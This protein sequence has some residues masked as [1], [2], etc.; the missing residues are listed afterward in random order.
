MKH[1]AN[2]ELPQWVESDR[3]L[4]TDFNEAMAKID[5]GLK[6]ALET[7][8]GRVTPEALAAASSNL[9]AQI[10]ACGNCRI[11][12][13]SY[14]GNGKYGKDNAVEIRFS[15]KP[16]LVLIG[17]YEHTSSGMFPS[18]LMRGINRSSS[19]SS[20]SPMQLEWAEKSVKMWVTDKD[21]S[22]WMNNDSGCQYYYVA[23]GT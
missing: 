15:I 8:E 16:M 4:M 20:N 11:A 14:T 22:T 13:G 1:T 6:S 7:A 23:F 10:A 21:S 5:S 17:C 9:S 3:I 18:I 2:Y 12:T 19:D